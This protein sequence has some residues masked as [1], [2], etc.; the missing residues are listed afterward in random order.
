MRLINKE[1]TKKK[2]TTKTHESILSNIPPCPLIMLEKSF[3]PFFLFIKLNAKSPKIEIVEKNKIIEII[4]NHHP[5]LF[6][7]I[8]LL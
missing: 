4:K 6:G 1:K 2:E 3:I 5:T 7:R 8:P